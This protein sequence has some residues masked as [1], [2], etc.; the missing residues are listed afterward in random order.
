MRFSDVRLTIWVSSA[1]G[2]WI[3]GKPF[4]RGKLNGV[5]PDDGGAVPV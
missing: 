1:L 4:A 3:F 5:C 2:T